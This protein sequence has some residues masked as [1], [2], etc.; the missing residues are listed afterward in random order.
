MTVSIA[1]QAALPGLE[2]PLGEVRLRPRIGFLFNHEH[3][4]QVAHSAPIAF[5]LSQLHEDVEVLIL[6][7]SPEQARLVQEL[8][9]RYPQHRCQMI[10]LE[11][12]PG[13]RALERVFGATVPVRK[14]GVLRSN[15]ALFRSFDALVVPEK[16]S[17]LL[18]TRFGCS[19]LKLIHTRHGAGDRA[20]G[21][22]RHS[23]AFDMVLL[24]GD[25]IRERLEAAGQL[26][27]R[28]KIV[29]YPK[30]DAV[31]ALQPQQPRPRLFDNDRPTVL[32][33]PHCSP[34]Q[35]S[36]YRWGAQVLEY[37]YQSNEYNLIF[38]PHVMLYRK[39]LQI[40]IDKLSVAWAA[41]PL[42]RYRDCPHMHIDLGSAA[43][44]DMSYTLAADLYLGDVS[45]QVCEFMVQ[46]R[47]CLF[48]N[49]HGVEWQN[50]PCFE[51]WQLG[52]VLDRP[53]GLGAALVSARATHAAYEDLQRR[54]FR[55]T[56]DL[57]PL[58]SAQ[59]AA[60]AIAEFVQANRPVVAPSP[61]DDPV[62]ASGLTE[63]VA[64]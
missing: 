24:A 43:S 27:K 42:Q 62:V 59:R 29:G 3:I 34:H 53:E 63:S 37:F 1:V 47:P 13:L 35:S 30:F 28:W 58:P 48:L 52:P 49:A 5:E 36:W 7:S 38:A 41:K 26:P 50:D 23:S 60:A 8:A 44:T 19:D 39:R 4:H 56:F 64:A 33:N 55:R 45:S 25:K 20:I 32:Y 46:P 16:T 22:D 51:A 54:Y 17:L 9:L 21:F 10:P 14:L 40:T 11:L 31:G 18:R 2:N 57:S 61:V 12:S 15:A 6:T